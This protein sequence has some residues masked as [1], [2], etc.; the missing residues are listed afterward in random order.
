MRSLLIPLLSPPAPA[1]PSVLD[2]LTGASASSPTRYLASMS[3]ALVECPIS[4][5]ASVASCPVPETTRSVYAKGRGTSTACRASRHESAK[6]FR[7]CPTLAT[8]DDG[9]GFWCGAKPWGC[10]TCN[11]HHHLL[12]SRVLFEELCHIVHLS[13]DRHPAVIL[14]CVLLHLH[15]WQSGLSASN[16]MHYVPLKP[17]PDLYGVP[18]G[19]RSNCPCG[20]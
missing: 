11:F 15:P 5:N 1:L 8:L 14:C 9:S 13:V 12:P 20:A 2:F 6:K 10:Q 3:R 17:K 4:S 7:W 19:N 18:H 16:H